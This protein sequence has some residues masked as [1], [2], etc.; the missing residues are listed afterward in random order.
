MSTVRTVLYRFYERSVYR[1]FQYIAEVVECTRHRY[2]TETHCTTGRLMRKTPL[3]THETENAT[4]DTTSYSSTTYVYRIQIY[5]TIMHAQK[6]EGL[7]FSTNQNGLFDVIPNVP[8]TYIQYCTGTGTVLRTV[9]GVFLCF[10]VRVPVPLFVSWVCSVSC[11]FSIHTAEGWR[12]N[13]PNTH[14]RAGTAQS[15]G[16]SMAR[17]CT[18]IVHF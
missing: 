2:C 12:R 8:Y 11:P 17:A 4:K 9:V 13:T 7:S 18:G 1:G 3:R 15:Y 10:Y 14:E 6:T 5:Y 16:T